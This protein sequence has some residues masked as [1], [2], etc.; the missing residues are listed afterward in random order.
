MHRVGRVVLA[1]PLLAL[2]VWLA[3]APGEAQAPAP[4]KGGVLRVGMIGEPPT[5]DAHATT[6]VITREITINVYEGLF[7][8]DAKYQPVP[9]LAESADVQDGGKRYVIRLRKDV[10][11]HNGKTLGSADVVASLKRWG[12]VASPG[13]AVFKNVES[14]EAKDPLTVELRLK[15]PSSA[16]LTILAHVDSAAVIYPKDVIDKAGDSPLKEYI[17]TGPFK[18]VEHRPDR[19]IKLARFDGY[20]SRSEAA[21]G[22]GGQRAAY[23]D[24]LLFLPV[25]DYATRQAGITTGEYQYI[26]QIK[27][28]QY[29]RIKT[30][31]G[32]EPIVVK[33]Y[34]WVTAVLN[35][36]QGVM[37]DKRLRQAIQ[38]ALDVE[39]MM[40][41]GLGHKDFYRLD[42]G[43][44]FQEQ[45]YHSRAGAAL[46]NQH[47][48]EKAKRLIK[49]AG[50]TGQP[51]R[52]IVT[53]EYEH[54]YKPALVA[55]SQ[56]EDVGFK[57]DMQVSDWATVVQRRAK[58]ELWDIFST[59]FVFVPE[60]TVTPQ[61]LCDWP[62]W[63][64]NPE[65]DALLQAMGRESDV[66]KRQAL[67]DKIQAVFYADA[68]RIKVGDYF[69]L[70]AR[71]KDVQG[72]EPGP[73]MHFW[74]VW[75]ERR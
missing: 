2:A 28:D 7:A 70:D 19:H 69:R 33:P 22:L 50:Y 42:P 45:A 71:R 31:A 55:K 56:L 29:D 6:A 16:L 10:K 63:W 14:L 61:V 53:T 27:P 13:K 57:I 74:N 30:T 4:K 17:G 49:E 58:P 46:Y 11:F 68:A 54:H 40:L 51:L 65:K 15:E 5:L 75:L 39:P 12:V 1:A 48:R 66:K 64:C 20:A 37:A 32:V 60:P 3:A 44:V 36:K 72:Y 26:Q 52:W 73:Y 35:T 9:L 34:G 59:A 25:P 47:D 67:W 41:A 24:E 43:I 18:F 62:G 38:A 8:L 23:V 21:N